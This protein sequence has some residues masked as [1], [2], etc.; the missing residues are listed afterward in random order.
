MMIKT[1]KSLGLACTLLAAS[2]SLYAKNNVVI[3]AT[4]GTIAGA[5]A[6]STNSATYTAAKVPVETL[7]NSVPQIKDLANVSGVQALQIASENITDKELLSL[8][9]QVNDLVKKPSVNG[10]VIT[11]GSDTL[12]ETAFFLNLVVHTDKP[13]VLVGS[14]RP[15]T[16][17]SADGPLNLYSAVALASS[18]EAKNKGVLV[19]MND[20]IFAARD[21]TKGINIHTNAFVSQW[22]A[23]GTVVE[24]KPY[25]FRN[26][27]KRHTKTS[28]FNIEQIKGEQLPVVQIVYGSDSM[29]P[30]AYLAYA[31]AGAQAIINAG[32]GNGSVAKYLVPTLQQLHDDNGIQIIRSSRVAQ[33]FVLRNAEQPDDKYGWVAAHDLD[34]QKARILAALALTK[35]NDAKEIQ[36]MFWEY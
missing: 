12:E 8:A 14:M 9:R 20:S 3:M 22:G 21:V 26:S 32:T 35:T 1:V 28:E 25:W 19:L 24:G 30:D 7:I 33:G 29:K 11:H 27:I 6:S 5:G 18:D 34:P 16:A 13:I 36:R 2:V 4:G 17:L 23:L 10:V 15:S 31:K